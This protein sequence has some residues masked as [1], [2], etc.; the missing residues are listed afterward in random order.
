M[1]MS[2][3]QKFERFCK[4]VL[5]AQRLL[6]EPYIQNVLLLRTLCS[7]FSVFVL[8]LISAGFASSYLFPVFVFLAQ[9]S[10]LPTNE[11][12]FARTLQE[13]GYKTAMIGAVASSMGM[14]D[15]SHGKRDNLVDCK[16]NNSKQSR[17]VQ[18]PTGKW[19]LGLNC[20]TPWDGCH[21]P[22]QH[23]FD[24]YFGLPLSNFRNLGELWFLLPG[25]TEMQC[26]A[27]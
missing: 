27:F 18:F 14:L 6:S 20:D 25:V 17:I 8:V 24:Y 11:T 12:T 22:L 19:H 4:E 23:G 7:L 1:L 3:L 13:N 9:K 16:T 26:E 5:L 2:H 21:G 10:G 15:L